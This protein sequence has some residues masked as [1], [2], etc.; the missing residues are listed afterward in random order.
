[1]FNDSGINMSWEKC[2][3]EMRKVKVIEYRTKSGIYGHAIGGLSKDQE[4]LFKAAK[5]LKPNLNHL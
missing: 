3:Y 1:M 2:L 5:C 4:K